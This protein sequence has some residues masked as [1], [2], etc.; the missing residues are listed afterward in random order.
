MKNNGHGRQ[1][2]NITDVYVDGS[3]VEYLGSF[4]IV[5]SSRKSYVIIDNCE[6]PVTYNALNGTCTIN[7]TVFAILT[8]A[9]GVWDL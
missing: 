6:F 7:P 9:E 5:Y 2:R 8:M 1:E 4:P 3:P